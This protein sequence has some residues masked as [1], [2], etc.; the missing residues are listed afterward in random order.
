MYLCHSDF[1]FVYKMLFPDARFS[2]RKQHNIGAAILQMPP[3]LCPT[4]HYE[5]TITDKNKEV[6]PSGK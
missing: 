6:L 4:S 5:V 3:L 2:K 1:Y